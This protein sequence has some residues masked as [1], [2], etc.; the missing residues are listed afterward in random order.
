M[1][2]LKSNS[3]T[4]SIFCKACYYLN[5]TKAPIC[6]QFNEKLRDIYDPMTTEL[7]VIKGKICL[8]VGV[9]EY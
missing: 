1:D 6:T 3:Q 7:M 4:T 9:K 8:G 5:K 2:N